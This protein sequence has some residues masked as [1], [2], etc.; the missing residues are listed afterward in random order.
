M[1]KFKKIR[2]KGFLRKLPHSNK[3][4]RIAGQLRKKPKKR[5]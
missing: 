1:P 4:I 5:K 3:K 2:I